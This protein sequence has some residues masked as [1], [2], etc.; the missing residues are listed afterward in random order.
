MIYNL[1]K[2]QFTLSVKVFQVREQPRHLQ[3]LVPDRGRKHRQE[4]LLV[5]D[6]I[7]DALDLHRDKDLPLDH[8]L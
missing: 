2:I 3:Q 7:L 1:G 4:S 6:D 5:R 8:C